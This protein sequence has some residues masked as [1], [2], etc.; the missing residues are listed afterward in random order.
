MGFRRLISTVESHTEG[1][2]TRV[3]TGGVACLPGATMEERRQYL[4][5]SLDGLRQMLMFEPRGHSAMSGAILQPP[6]SPGSDFGVLFIESTG[7]LPMCGHGTIGVATVLVETGMVEVVEPVTTIRLDVPAGVVTVAVQVRDG[8]AQ[9][10]TLRSVPAFV[11]ALDVKVSVPGHGVVTL[12]LAYGGNFYAI[13]PGP[14]LGVTVDR[15]H[16]RELLEAGLAV[17]RAVNEQCE[18]VHP[19]LR[20]VRGC[21][22]V[23]L[24]AEDATARRSP[25][26][27]V[28]HPGWIDR[29]PC[30]TGTSARMAQLHARG[31]LPVDT[32]LVSVSLIGSE[33][34]GRITGLTAVGGTEA[35]LPE[36]RGRAW[37]TGTANWF[38]DP[39]DPFP[40]GFLL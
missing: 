6:I 30:G 40:E 18:P 7:C 12:D 36:I 13:C 19:V 2:S 33:F 22:H 28:I 10:V 39:E 31:E 3:V 9:S 37:I 23:N 4:S 5:S 27:M 26:A 25:H 15:A 20:T 17:M 35:V 8:R 14:G 24:L 16:V 29:S 11:H 38:V 34:V 1:M 32:D 21:H